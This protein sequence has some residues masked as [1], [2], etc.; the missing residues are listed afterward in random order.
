MR[1]V[2]QDDK[3]EGDKEEGGKQPPPVSWSADSVATIV[4]IFIDGKA[5]QGVGKDYRYDK[6]PEEDI[7][8]GAWWNHE[9]RGRKTS[10]SAE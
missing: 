1:R 9:L 10:T 8:R 5:L 7:Q 4:S 3:K 2:P 6:V